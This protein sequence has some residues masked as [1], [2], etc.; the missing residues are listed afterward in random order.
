MEDIYQS[1]ETQEF[2]LNKSPVAQQA[3]ISNSAGGTASNTTAINKVIDT[4]EAYGL[5]ATVTGSV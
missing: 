1:L 2:G 3:G 4:L 5:T